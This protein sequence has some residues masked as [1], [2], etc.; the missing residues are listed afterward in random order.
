MLAGL[1]APLAYMGVNLANRRPFQI[2]K[3][4]NGVLQPVRL[5]L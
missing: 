2:L 1:Q 5:C 4:M 3:D